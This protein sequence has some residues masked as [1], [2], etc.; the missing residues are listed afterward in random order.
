L[1]R[2]SGVPNGSMPL[3]ELPL[4]VVL[5]IETS[6]TGEAVCPH[7]RRR[8][9]GAPLA[10]MGTLPGLPNDKQRGPPP[11]RLAPERSGDGA[12]PEAVMSRVPAERAVRRTAQALADKH[13]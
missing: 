4:I 2:T 1:R 7:D 12:N 5:S 11:T 9:Q 13:R 8:T 6:M 10:P 3:K